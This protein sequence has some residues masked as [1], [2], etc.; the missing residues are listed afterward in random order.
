MQSGTLIPGSL[1]VETEPC[2]PGWELI[3]N[4]DGDTI[5]RNIRKAGWNFFFLAA[6]MQVIVWGHWTEKILRKAMKRVLAKAQPAQF[7][8]LEVTELS[9]RRVLGISYVHLSAHSRHI[10]K[11]L[12]LQ[13]LAER[14]QAQAAPVKPEYDR[15]IA[16]HRP[17]K[18]VSLRF[19]GVGN[20][21]ENRSQSTEQ[22]ICR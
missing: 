5:D 16:S 14:G 4:S 2:L 9:A 1:R 13:G 10:Q 21:V 22:D 6:N 3:K 18:P 8:C 19:E 12:F 7:N 11:G 17:Q 20:A 15:A